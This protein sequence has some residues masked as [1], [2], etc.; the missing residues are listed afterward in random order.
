[1]WLEDIAVVDHG[2]WEKRTNQLMMKLKQTNKQTD[3]IIINTEATTFISW[4]RTRLDGQGNKV[5]HTSYL[6][7]VNIHFSNISFTY[8]TTLR[9]LF[10]LANFERPLS[11]VGLLLAGKMHCL[12]VNHV[13]FSNI[14]TRCKHAWTNMLVT[15]QL[16]VHQSTSIID[17][18]KHPCCV[19][20]KLHDRPPLTVFCPHSA[21]SRCDRC[22]CSADATEQHTSIYG[23]WTPTE[24]G[25][26]WTYQVRRFDG[27][28]AQ[29]YVE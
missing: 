28:A 10:L 3:N 23:E 22:L 29:I 1:M 15:E 25:I 9:W 13:F 7:P 11:D 21:A 12:F 20:W 14:P 8:S 26:R 18:G 16:P 5:K 2:L 24:I 6:Y 27:N 4:H 19:I 17:S